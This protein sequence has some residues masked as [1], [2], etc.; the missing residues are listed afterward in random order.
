MEPVPERHQGEIKH[1]NDGVSCSHPHGARNEVFALVSPRCHCR[2]VLHWFYSG[3]TEKLKLPLYLSSLRKKS[4][5]VNYRMEVS[6]RLL[7]SD[8]SGI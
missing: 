5:P 2:L 7:A 3:F 4:L 8:Y 1:E 6:A